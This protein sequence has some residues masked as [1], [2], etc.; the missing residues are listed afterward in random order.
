MVYVQSCIHSEIFIIKYLDFVASDDSASA[1]RTKRAIHDQNPFAEMF[2]NGM[3]QEKLIEA[4]YAP[5]GP[6]WELIKVIVA[7][8]LNETI[9]ENTNTTLA[10]IVEVFKIHMEALRDTVCITTTGPFY[11][12]IIEQNRETI[13]NLLRDFLRDLIGDRTLPPE[14]PTLPP[15]LP[16][17]P[18]AL[19]P[20][21]SS[22]RD[23]LPTFT[24]PAD[25]QGRN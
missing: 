6:I 20:I 24:P 19:R 9:V 7:P 10:R 1:K 5:D 22:L 11:R 4:M 8:R 15:G 12:Q 13:I 2:R 25:Q 17:I 14:L 23:L 21:I 16:T 3:G 18:P